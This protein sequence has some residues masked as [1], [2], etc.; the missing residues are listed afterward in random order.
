VFV[1]FA[2]YDPS[3]RNSFS[4]KAVSTALLDDVS[5][6]EIGSGLEAMSVYEQF[7]SDRSNAIEKEQLKSSL[8]TYCETDCRATYELVGFLNR[9]K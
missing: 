2:Y 5:W 6:P 8:I 9:L 7:R 4:L 1:N 3:F